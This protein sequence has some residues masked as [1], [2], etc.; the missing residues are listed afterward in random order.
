MSNNIKN[1]VVFLVLIISMNAMVD[2]RYIIIGKTKFTAL[3]MCRESCLAKFLKIQSTTRGE[4]GEQ[5]TNYPD[6]YMCYD[7]CGMLYKEQRTI[8]IMM[9]S[10][11]VCVSFNFY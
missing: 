10:D 2:G 6:C 5:C 3:Q 8:V 4:M 1:F 9:C 11:E 7:Y